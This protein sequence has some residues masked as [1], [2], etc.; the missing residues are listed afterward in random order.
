M[1]LQLLVA[2]LLAAAAPA[3]KAPPPV[4]ILGEWHGT[5]LC[6]DRVFAPACKDEV[7]VYRF[8]P[9]GKDTARCSAYKIVAGEEQWM[10]DLD[11]TPRGRSNDWLCDMRTARYHGNWRFHITDTLLTGDL[12]DVPTKKQVRRVRAMRLATSKPQE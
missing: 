5:S 7:V 12:I 3:A 9:A 4:S 8:T 10:G 6:V 11:F 2:A 1:R